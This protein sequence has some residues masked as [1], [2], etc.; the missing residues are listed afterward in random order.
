MR[1]YFSVVFALLILINACNTGKK[2][3]D[4]TAI[5][6]EIKKENDRFSLYRG[7]EPYFINGA[8]GW[9]FLDE[10]TEAGA[11]SV[12][13]SYRFLDEAHQKGL[14]V[15][16]NLPM[17]AERSGFDYNDAQAV[18]EQYLKNRGIVEEYKDHPAVLMWAIGNE[19]DHIPGDKDYNLKVWDDINEIINN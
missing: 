5:K 2:S 17:G 19:L 14:T 9:G 16:V 10:M 7:G 3:P 1:T 8:V 18:R 4:S 13:S 15:L 12:R 6:A 11:N